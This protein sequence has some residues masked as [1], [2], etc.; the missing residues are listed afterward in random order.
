LVFI[1]CERRLSRKRTT[2]HQS[3]DNSQLVPAVECKTPASAENDNAC[4]GSKKRLTESLSK[5]VSGL[6]SCSNTAGEA[7]SSVDESL[8]LSPA[9]KRCRS[10]RTRLRRNNDSAKHESGRG[11]VPRDSGDPG[12]S[13]ACER[14]LKRKAISSQPFDVGGL[15]SMSSCFVRLQRVDVKRCSEARSSAL[16]APDPSSNCESAAVRPAVLQPAVKDGKNRGKRRLSLRRPELKQQSRVTNSGATVRQDDESSSDSRSAAQLESECCATVFVGSESS[17]SRRLPN[18]SYS[19]S[20]LSSR[21]RLLDD[22]SCSEEL[23]TTGRDSTRCHDVLADESLD[24]RCYSERNRNDKRLSLKLRR[25]KPDEV[26]LQSRYQQRPESQQAF[27]AVRDNKDESSLN[28]SEH[29]TA[30]STVITSAYDHRQKLSA[31]RSRSSV[32]AQRSSSVIS[33]GESSGRRLHS[34]LPIFERSDEERFD[35]FADVL[36]HLS[37]MSSPEP[38]DYDSSP[39]LPSSPSVAETVGSLCFS[40]EQECGDQSKSHAN[41]TADNLSG[42]RASDTSVICETPPED[43]TV[44]LTA[45]TDADAC[46]ASCSGGRRCEADDSRSLKIPRTIETVTATKRVT[47]QSAGVVT[48]SISL[49]GSNTGLTDNTSALIDNEGVLFHRTQLRNKFQSG[50]CS[51]GND[52][53]SSVVWS[54]VVGPPSHQ[55]ILMD[56]VAQPRLVQSTLDAFCS[57]PRDLP[58]KQK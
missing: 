2:R 1:E 16:R 34:V 3:D 11:S 32:T 50:V 28:N 33:P 44:E 41:I 57:D 49:D 51:L 46:N 23:E 53:V 19:A 17:E 6:K 56:L 40:N 52:D 10:A 8:Q 24:E 38:S 29:S 42:D 36:C 9:S 58:A 45:M 13:V 22:G 47:N 27:S 18:D 4:V 14:T 5:L 31:S 20:R 39:P 15:N 25:V 48:D 12:E 7:S 43:M 21:E 37:A 35:N 54:P 55:D 30:V 26:L